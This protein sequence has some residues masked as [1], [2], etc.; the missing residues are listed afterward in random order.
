MHNSH[1]SQSALRF[2]HKNQLSDAL[3]ENLPGDASTRHYSRLYLGGKSYIFAQ[4]PKG[5]DD[6]VATVALTQILAD[7]GL[8]V[9]EVLDYD[10]GYALILF[11]DFG[12]SLYATAIAQ[13]A[14]EVLL[15]RTACDVLVHLHKQ[16]IPPTLKLPDG[17]DYS[18][19][20]CDSGRL[21]AEVALFV[22]WYPG[23]DKDEQDFAHLWKALWP[24]A[25]LEKPVLVQFDYHSPNLIWLP[26]REGLQRV[27]ILDFQ[28]S[29]LGSR[30][31]DLVSLLQ[32][33]RRDVPADLESDMIEYYLCQHPKLNHRSFRQAYA[34]MGA[35]R[36]TRILGTFARLDRRD[37]KSHYLNFLPKVWDLLDRNLDHPAC[38]DL[39][40]F[41]RQGNFARNLSPQAGSQP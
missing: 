17:A 38:G 34:I 16:E 12:D 1:L 15:Y 8:S 39:A 21:S 7:F 9:P 29:F 11:E 20:Q 25:W 5:T 33:P 32:D 19:S 18:L 37:G 35:Q 28:D 10:L 3:I 22:Q 23:A 27:G 31:Y 13:G 30:A 14:E 4:V 6:I 40:R 26:D 36:M 41:F 2:L 24:L